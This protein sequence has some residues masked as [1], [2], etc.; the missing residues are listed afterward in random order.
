MAEIEIK[1]RFWILGDHYVLICVG[2][3]DRPE[4]WSLVDL[5]RPEAT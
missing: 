2:A 1:T 5:N 4:C 3:G